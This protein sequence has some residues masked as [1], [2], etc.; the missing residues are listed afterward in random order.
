MQRVHHH[1]LPRE[2][3]SLDLDEIARQGAQKMLAQALQVE[4]DAYLKAA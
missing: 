1:E 3:L 4:V 2:Q